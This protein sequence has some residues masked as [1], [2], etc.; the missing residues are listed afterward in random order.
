MGLDTQLGYL[1]GI[2]GLATGSRKRPHSSFS[3]NTI[4]T[5]GGLSSPHH[6][7][8]M[9]FIFNELHPFRSFPYNFLVVIH[10]MTGGVDSLNER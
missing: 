9:D 4:A 10:S 1:A 2:L 3:A 5:L 6:T 7:S 8:Q